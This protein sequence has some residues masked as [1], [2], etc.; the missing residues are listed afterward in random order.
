MT[1]RW[2]LVRIFVRC[3]ALGLT[4]ATAQAAAVSGKLHH[5]NNTPA[6][7]IAVTLSNIKGRSAPVQSDR[8]GSYTLY[9]IPAGVYNLEVWVNRNSPQTFKVTVREPNTSVGTQTVP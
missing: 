6:I 4:S 2:L 9:N 7:G 5:R 1:T 3:I 8:S